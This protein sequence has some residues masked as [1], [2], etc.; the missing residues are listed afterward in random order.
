VS[1]Q[2]AVNENSEPDA[3]LEELLGSPLLWKTHK[4]IVRAM[5]GQ[6]LGITGPDLDLM[7]NAPSAHKRLN[8]LRKLGVVEARG[9][10]NK[11]ALWFLTW[12]LP[13][14]FVPVSAYERP[15]A[16]QPDPDPNRIREPVEIVLQEEVLQRCLPVLRKLYLDMM[17]T[18]D[19]AAPDIKLL[20]GWVADMMPTQAALPAAPLPPPKAPPKEESKP[21]PPWWS[22]QSWFHD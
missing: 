15:T 5:A 1:S 10:R 3:S 21:Q 17:R 8:E 16:P 13:A 22:G 6:P 9:T 20:S 18:K 4:V 12:K 2:R 7:L 11:C 14:V 19:S